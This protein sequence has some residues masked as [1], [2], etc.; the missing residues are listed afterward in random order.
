M[1]GVMDLGMKNMVA[2]RLYPTAFSGVL[3]AV[4]RGAECE[5]EAM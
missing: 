3:T 2:L 4:E 1:K 5:F